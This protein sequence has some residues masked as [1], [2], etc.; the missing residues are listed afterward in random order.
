M[1]VSVNRRAGGRGMG[2]G[3]GVKIERQM[4]VGP[5]HIVPQATSEYRLL[6]M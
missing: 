2:S 4:K 3:S 1:E 6:S 5:Y